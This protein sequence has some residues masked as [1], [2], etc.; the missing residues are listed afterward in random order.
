MLILTLAA[1][2]AVVGLLLQHAAATQADTF[3]SATTAPAA[4]SS[5]NHALLVGTIWMWSGTITTAGGVATLALA[6]RK[7]GR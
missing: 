1:V 7:R 2:A 6:L 4:I 3:H 5:T